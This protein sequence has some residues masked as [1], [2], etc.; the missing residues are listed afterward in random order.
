MGALDQPARRHSS[1]QLRH[2]PRRGLYA[3]A[4]LMV[5][6]VLGALLRCSGMSSELWFDEIFSLRL[7]EPM[8][9]VWQV[10]WARHHD[11]KHHLIWL[12][13]W[14]WGPGREEWIYRL[15]SL[16]AGVA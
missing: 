12:W 3:I 5:L 16:V 13:L 14:L 8:K 10:L 4:L 9:N 1:S 11:N 7:A 15:P 6:I 2:P